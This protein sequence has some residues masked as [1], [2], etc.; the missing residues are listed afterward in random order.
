MPW[1]VLERKIG[2]KRI[3]DKKPRSIAGALVALFVL[4]TMCLFPTPANAQT[5]PAIVVSQ[6]SW[7]GTISGGGFLDGGNPFG[8]SFAVN[9]NGDV[10]VSNTYGSSVYLFN[11]KTG[12]VTTLSSSF[13]NPGAITV[14]NKN[15]LYISHI[16]NSLIYKVPYV[17]GT[18][19]V[20]D[21]TSPYPPYCTGNDTVECQ[22]VK[23]G[24]SSVKAMAFDASGNFFMATT[25]S[26]TGASAIYEC[27]L[28][29]QPNPSGTS[30]LI[31][32]D[33]NAVGAI[34]TDPWG[35]LF[36]TDAAFSGAPSGQV[37]T[38]SALNELTYTAGTG[39]APT[40]IQLATYADAPVTP[41][42]DSL[43]AVGVDAN[44]TVYYA[45]QYNGMLAL[46]NNHGSINTS[47]VYGVSTQGGKALALDSR[48]N[49]Y[50]VAYNGSSDAVGKALINNI[51][52]PASTVGNA[53]TANVT[54]M[55]NDGG[56]SNNPVLNFSAQEN[57]VALN[58]TSGEFIG[59]ATGT[60]AGQSG[61]SDFAATI[62]F[63]P[64]NVGERTAVLTVSDATNGGS[65]T[66][67][68]F[69]TGQGPL[70]TLSP[71]VN[72][73]YTTGFNSPS[74]ISVDS[75]GNMFVADSGAHS[76]FK[77]AL[78]G[79]IPTAIGTG[80]T[81]PSGTAFDAAGNLY[82]ADSTNN[83][84]VEIPNVGGSL[85]PASQVTLV[86]NTA[87]FA[88][89]T[90]NNPTGLAVSP[91]GTLYIAD[92][93]NNRVVTYVLGSSA[94][95][96]STGVRVTGLNSPMG[97]A[98]DASCTLYIANMGAGN[99]LVYSG[100]TITTL[101]PTG[102]TTPA[103]VAVEPSGSVLIADKSTGTIVRVPNEA[104]TLTS[105]D[106]VVVASNPKSASSVALDVAGNLYTT[107]AT[108]AAAYAV[109][110]TASAINFGIVNA[111]S[112]ST[113]S[114]I[115][116]ENAGNTTLSASTPILGTLSSTQFTLAAGSPVGCTDG[117]TI[118]SGLAC[119]FSAQFSPAVGAS[120]PYSATSSVSS[121]ALNAASAVITLSGTV[122]APVGTPQ[123]I[124]FTAPASPVTFGVAPIALSATATS[125][126]SVTFSIVSGPGSISGSTLTITGA[127]TVVVAANQAGDA[128]YAPASQVTQSIVVSQVSQTITFAAP[129]S[130]VPF[131]VAPIALSATADSGLPVAFS[132]VSGPG[133][134]SGSTLTIT[135]VG[136]V[137]VAAN[138]AG[139]ANYT[140][141]TQATQSIAVNQAS[142]TIS[143]TAPTTPV[144]Y[145]AVAITLSATAS[146]GLPVAFSVVSGP[147][148]VSGGKLTVTGVGTV[149]V[150]ANQAGNANYAAATQVTHSV[151]VSVIGTVA[152]PTFTPAAGTYTSAQSVTISSATTGAV[153]YYTTDGSTPSTS[154]TAYS[155]AISVG[156]TE[157]IQAIAV[158][159]G[160][161][162]STVASAAYTVN[163]V[164]S[165]TIAVNPASLTVTSGT[166]GTF[167][168]TVTPQN[169]FNSAVTFA[170]SG[171]PTGAT[172]AF[173]PA[174]VTPTAGT[175]STTVT[176]TS[177]STTA[178]VRHNSNPLFPEA[179][180]ALALCFFGFRK[181]R[182]VQIML[183]LVVTAI[184]LGMLSGCGGSSKQATTSTVTVTATSG[185]IQQTATLSLTMQ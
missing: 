135:G 2:S 181:R 4:A 32:S 170:C 30:T 127:G 83:Q 112:S 148:T 113:A 154:S 17:N 53:A 27:N 60:C 22:F 116:V 168:L 82:V 180:F 61:G 131:G 40:P 183:V 173:N 87:A 13:S 11:G 185:T 52:I 161:T 51:A 64:T 1:N 115:Y 108:G 130:P 80:F 160:Y 48:G 91:G 159:P 49:V 88:G 77:I 103:S 39:Y 28:A 90:L 101:S 110:Q 184:G 36:F 132:V 84:I 133:T 164:P 19:A 119:E 97:I 41:G 162:N 71:G 50:V 145:G 3:F 98:V 69:G 165:F 79:S 23:A 44:G 178:A 72:T 155:G 171:M 18:Y 156:A 99:V 67:T 43:G 70:V 167:N 35:N 134:V 5:K 144:T 24:T 20:S 8:G 106:A 123:T 81:A 10:I 14:D 31:Y 172:C 46:P 55:V 34:A 138:Q 175:A 56:C 136:T 140:A 111:G 114:T 149:V 25:P 166:P 102:V 86:A 26:G 153:I 141:A 16:Y 150:A 182:S 76:L 128:T 68:A 143:F 63:T 158:A 117:S 74:S 66:A 47:N 42:D 139:N 169:G 177:S 174:T 124:S 96:G 89:T 15:N 9:Q 78:G 62:T 105:A 152:T 7:L 93:G 118:N 12:V 125:G 65:G 38:S 126:L 179:T 33:T 73:A 176:I 163:I 157:T 95:P 45:T 146:S 58:G 100:G 57:G 147:G 29:C 122:P 92:T 137:V 129:A 104:G 6:F 21:S 107:D 151:V 94:V 142:Q 85:I 109:Q 54:V 37:Y 121:N 75:T 59:A 120:G